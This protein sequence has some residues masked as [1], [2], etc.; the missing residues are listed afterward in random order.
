MSP[1]QKKKKNEQEFKEENEMEVE[2]EYIRPS[3]TTKLS[4]EHY[5]QS[6]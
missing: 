2:G 4:H 1:H 3:K 6:P 5:E